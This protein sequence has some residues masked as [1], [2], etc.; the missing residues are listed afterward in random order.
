MGESIERRRREP[1][2]PGVRSQPQQPRAADRAR[3]HAR[4][5]A[6]PLDQGRGARLRLGL[7]RR[8]P[9]LQAALRPDHAALGD[10]AANRAGQARHRLPGRRDPQPA[11]SGARVGDARR[12]LGRPHDPRPVH[13][14]PR[15]GRPARV[16]G[17]RAAVQEARLRSSRR[18]SRSSA[19]LWTEGKITFHGDYFDYDEVEFTPAPRWRR[20]GPIQKPPPIWVVSNPRLVGRLP[21]ERDGARSWSGPPS[22][23]SATA[24]AG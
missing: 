9:V 23:S 17:G 7:G 22:G 13:G 15:E 2:G 5:P 24:T 21:D 18:S 14:Q 12:A 20:S 4:G 19:Q 8:Q 3:L 1:E 10:L 6:R 16:R 11:L